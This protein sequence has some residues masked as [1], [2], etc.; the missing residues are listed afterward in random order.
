LPICALSENSQFLNISINSCIFS[1]DEKSISVIDYLRSLM[2]QKENGFYILDTTKIDL[3]RI[4]K[5]FGYSEAIN[6]DI[7][8]QNNRER[9]EMQVL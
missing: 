3:P 9:N 6:R 1:H 2:P 5:S 7:S 4:L 8:V